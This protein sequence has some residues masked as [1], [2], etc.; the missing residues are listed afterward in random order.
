[1]EI[2]SS[3]AIRALCAWRLLMSL[4][5]P[6]ITVRFIVVIL[7]FTGVTLILTSEKE[8]RIGSPSSLPL[9]LC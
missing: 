4:A 6:H 9:L 7:M 1:M 5:F 8:T 3:L 2:K